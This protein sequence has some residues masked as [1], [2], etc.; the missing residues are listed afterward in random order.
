MIDNAIPLMC[1]VCARQIFSKAG[2]VDCHGGSGFF[3]IW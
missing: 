3:L 2:A 1:R